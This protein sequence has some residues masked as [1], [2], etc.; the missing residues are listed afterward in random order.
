MVKLQVWK[1]KS[2]NVVPAKEKTSLGKPD[3]MSN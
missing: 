2:E 1:Q 3:A